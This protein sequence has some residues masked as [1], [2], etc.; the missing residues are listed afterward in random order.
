[1]VFAPFSKVVGRQSLGKTLTHGYAQSFVAAAQGSQTVHN[2]T[3]NR[4]SQPNKGGRPGSARF[5]TVFRS[6]SNSAAVE[7]R[8]TAKAGNGDP[9]SNQGLTAY[10]DAWQKQHPPGVEVPE[11]KQFQFQKTIGWKTVGKS[12]ESR[13]AETSELKRVPDLFFN[14]QG[15]ARTHSASTVDDIKKAKARVDE[16]VDAGSI[17]NADISLNG[18]EY[19]IH[20]TLSETEPA[21]TLSTAE[22]QAAVINDNLASSPSNFSLSDSFGA[23]STS[24]SDFSLQ[25]TTTEADTRARLTYQKELDAAVNAPTAEHEKVHNALH[26]YL[27]ALGQGLQPSRDFYIVLIDF[28]CR[29]ALDV[30][31]QEQALNLSRRRFGGFL[32]DGKFLLAS[33]DVE[34]TMLKEDDAINKA[35]RIFDTWNAGKNLGTLPSSTYHSLIAASAKHGLIQD[36]MRVHNHQ[37]DLHIMPHASTFPLMIEALGVHGDMKSAIDIYG[38][39]RN[40]AIQDHSGKPAITGRQDNDVYA[41]VVRAYA[42][43]GMTSEI[44]RF[45]DKITSSIASSPVNGALLTELQDVIVPKGLIKESIEAQAFER[46][47]QLVEEHNLSP[48]VQARAYAEIG[49]AAADADCLDVASQAS[50]YAHQE[51]ADLQT[52]L[53]ALHVRAGSLDEARRAWYNISALPDMQTSL[54]EPTVM[55]TLALLGRGFYDEAMSEIRQAFSRIRATTTKSH[56]LQ[57]AKDRIDEAIELVGDAVMSPSTKR[58][59]FSTIMLLRTMSENS[60]LITP[61][62]EHLIASLGSHN[63]TSLDHQDI[64]LAL[65][66]QVQ[67]LKTATDADSAGHHAR[68]S[69]LI[70][71]LLRRG[72]PIEDHTRVVVDSVLNGSRSFDR[73]LL[74]RWTERMHPRQSAPVSPASSRLPAFIPSHEPYAASTDLRASNLIDSCFD[75]HR[76]AAASQLDEA[77]LRF[78]DCRRLGRHPRPSTYA[79]LIFNAAKERRSRLTHELLALFRSDMPF[80]EGQPLSAQAHITVLDSMLAAALTVGDRSTATQC[81][82]DILFMGGAPSANTYGLYITNLNEGSM[83]RV[84]DEATEAVKIFERARKEGVELTS[85]LFNALIGKLSKARR[86]DDTLRYFHEMQMLN[87]RPTSVTY[88]TVIS[89]LCRVSNASLAEMLFN[90]MED[91]PNYRPRAAPYNSIMQFHLTTSLDSKAVLSYYNRMLSHNIAPT[92]HTFKLLIDTYATLSPTNIYAAERILSHDLPDAR[93][94]PEATHFS[95]L[96]HAKGCVH[97]D[98]S[99]AL[100]TFEAALRRVPPHPALYQAL[101]ESFTANHD[102]AASGPHLAHMRAHGVKITPYIANALIKGWSSEKATAKGA[103][104]DKAKSYYDALGKEKREPSTYEAMVRGLLGVGRKEE[105]KEVVAECVGRG[106]PNAVVEKVV[107][108]LGA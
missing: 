80:I 91:Q 5:H 45:V 32:E 48:A 13:H 33:S 10:Y 106:Y 93:I 79:K 35:L 1:M 15:L 98:M 54:I 22:P 12:L 85:F 30:S 50:Q 14:R 103:D 74:Y 9:S 3:F 49:S 64:V 61:I 21:H 27:Q 19:T 78:K 43:W 4:S 17:V 100:S 97:S 83:E 34:Y 99:G 47:L 70:D 53:L 25:A 44:Q 86:I 36:M 81:H 55:Y 77:L 58:S 24:A 95:S 26:I 69:F 107:S 71:T 60:G 18:D 89:A 7:G 105:A 59:A 39:Y 66:C 75:Q 63:I 8:A 20:R 76:A 108:V 68:F 104:V 40:L 82:Q 31:R 92:S 94:K 28:L 57:E 73:T 46:A 88:G 2:H 96:I 51:S 52:S 11:W 65:H 67:I 101:F 23:Q 37:V 90:E 84:F 42:T 72:V 41:A 102:I 56:D 87:I 29:R 38:S 6:T 62:A 16:P